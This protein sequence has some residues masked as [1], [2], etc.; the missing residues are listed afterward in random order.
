MNGWVRNHF[1]WEEFY[2]G[3]EIPRRAAPRNDRAAVGRPVVH[4]RAQSSSALKHPQ[5][6]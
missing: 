5:D 4:H 6:E 1:V 2:V 3:I